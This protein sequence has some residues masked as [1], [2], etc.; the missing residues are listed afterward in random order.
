MSSD[1]PVG[2]LSP[3]R[4]DGSIETLLRVL[5]LTQVRCAVA[6]DL[7]ELRAVLQAALDQIREIEAEHREER[8]RLSEQLELA[9]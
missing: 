8:A 4:A 7:C 5:M 6:G 3:L 9:L 2:P 1:V